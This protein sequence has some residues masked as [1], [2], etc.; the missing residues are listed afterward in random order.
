MAWRAC[1]AVI[2]LNGAIGGSTLSFLIP[3]VAYTNFKHSHSM[4][5]ARRAF[6]LAGFSAVIAVLFTVGNT[7][8]TIWGIIFGDGEGGGGVGDPDSPCGN[9]PNI[10][11]D[12][13]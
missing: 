2:A 13:R 4:S 11:P 10:L 9:H 8:L 7:G 6:T 3:S 12:S 1:R 5:P